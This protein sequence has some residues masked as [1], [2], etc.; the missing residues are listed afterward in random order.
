MKEAESEGIGLGI[1]NRYYYYELPTLDNL[2]TIFEEFEGSPIGYWHDTGHAHANEV[3]GIIRR[4]ELLEAYGGRLLGIHVHDARGLEDHLVPGAGEIDF[5]AKIRH[6]GKGCD[7][8][9]QAREG[10]CGQRVK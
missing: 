4:G 3:L 6:P 9:D 8:G 2:R 7:K 5:R 1:E 10:G